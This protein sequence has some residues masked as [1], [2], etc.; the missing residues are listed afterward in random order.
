[1]ENVFFYERTHILMFSLR[2]NIIAKAAWGIR[3]Q[4]PFTAHKVPQA[5]RR[6]G[7]S[8]AANG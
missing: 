6:Y 2:Q 5:G 1:M 3:S 4:R 8:G 7:T